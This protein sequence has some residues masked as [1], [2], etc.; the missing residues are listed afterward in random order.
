MLEFQFFLVN[1][2]FTINLLAA[3]V[4]FAVSWL[5]FDA[6]LTARDYRESTKS[7]G[8]L[9]LSISFVLHATVIEQSLLEQSLLGSGIVHFLVSFFRFGAYITLIWGQIAD[10]IQPLPSYRSQKSTAVI[11]P[12]IG[13]PLEQAVPFLFPLLAA[14]LAFLYIRRATV[15]LE[16]HL[17]P[18]SYS[19]FGLA[20]FELV[21][22]AAVF[23]ESSS[24]TVQGIVNAFGPFWMLE[25]LLLIFSMAILGKWVWGYLIKRL[26]TQLFIIFTSSILVVFLLTA[27]FFTTVSLSNLKYDT[28]ESLETS[29]KVLEYSID[30][31]KAEVLSDA[32]LLAQNPEIISAIKS[33]SR[34]QLTDTTVAMLKAK[35]ESFVTVVSDT[36]A[37]LVRGDDPENLG[38]SLSG[39]DLVKQAL[40]GNSTAALVSAEGVLTPNISVRAAAP[41]RDAE[42]GEVQGVI[43]VGSAVDNAFLDGLKNATGLEASVYAGNVRSATTF[44]AADGKSR[45]VGVK[46]ETPIVKRTVLGEG[47]IFVG[48]VPILQTPYFAAFTPLFDINESAVGMLFVGRPQTSTLRAAASLIEQTFLVTVILLLLSIIPSYLVSRYIIGQIR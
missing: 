13:F 48:S 25:H 30:S 8:F 35:Q 9:M 12:L 37:V 44:L 4:C 29:V 38:G 31:K 23:R 27:I 26:E 10:P 20:F 46:E 40:A 6:W 41:V 33:K 42:T 7:L 22:L 39:D 11:V 28:L 36:G 5:Y 14:A 45:W 15:G 17:K 1:A 16:H 47:K 2:H 18:I 19:F 24:I 34:K 43:L 21:S 3:L 32:E